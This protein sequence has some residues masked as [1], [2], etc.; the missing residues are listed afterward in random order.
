MDIE[1]WN[2]II[3][4]DGKKWRDI[5][6]TAKTLRESKFAEINRSRRRKLY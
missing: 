2:T 6:I 5:L 3:V 1:D 4:H